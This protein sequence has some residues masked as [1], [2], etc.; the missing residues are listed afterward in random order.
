MKTRWGY[1][2]SADGTIETVAPTYD[3]TLPADAQAQFD[4]AV[5]QALAQVDAG[6][7]DVEKALALHDYLAVHC[8]YNWAV[9]AGNPEEAPDTVYSA[10][11]ALVEGDAVCQGYALA[12][13][14]LLE[15]AG[16]PSAMLTSANHMWNLVQLGGDWYHVDVTWDDPGAGYPGDRQPSVFPDLGC[17]PERAGHRREPYL[18]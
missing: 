17:P 13:R 16:I 1:R 7:D 15:E 2:C 6:M 9:A 11:G 4:A 10:Y 5:T 8:G 12:Y 3:T 14:L 18:E